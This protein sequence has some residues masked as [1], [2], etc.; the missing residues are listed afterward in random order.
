MPRAKAKGPHV[1][2]LDGY[3]R[4]VLSGKI[5]ACKWIR[6]ACERHLADLKRARAKDWPYKFNAELAERA[7]RF[8]E[9]MPHVKGKW[10]AGK[11]PARLKMAAWQVFFIGS[12]YGWV[13][14]ATGKRRKVSTTSR[15][16]R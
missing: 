12:I 10:A 11:T 3:V 15:P 7:C 5:P 8:V 1:A 2:T 14:K 4:D 16:A 13:N 9:L 6:L